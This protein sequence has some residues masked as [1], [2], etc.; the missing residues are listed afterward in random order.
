MTEEGGSS[1]PAAGGKITVQLADDPAKPRSGREVPAGQSVVDTLASGAVWI[2]SGAVGI[3]LDGPMAA[4][5]D[6]QRP[7]EPL[8]V[9]PSKTGVHLMVMAAES[10]HR[11]W[12]AGFN[13]GKN[14]SQEDVAAAGRESGWADGHR[15]GMAEGRAAL[16]AEMRA[17]L[18]I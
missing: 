6:L 2:V 3:R 8:I 17:L 13:A 1:S 15:R 9:L 16:Q 5:Y 18:A 11:A 4:S 7:D 12:Y 14:A 10:A